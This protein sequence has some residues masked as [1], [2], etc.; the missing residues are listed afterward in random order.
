MCASIKQGFF[1][2]KG[3]KKLF[4]TRVSPVMFRMY[5][6]GANFSHFQQA[7]GHIKCQDIRNLMV[8]TNSMVKNL[9]LEIG[10]FLREPWLGRLE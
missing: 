1:Q 7:S 4:S 9:A 10:P 6:K 2:H 8:F 5:L 3:R